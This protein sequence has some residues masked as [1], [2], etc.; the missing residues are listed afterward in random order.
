MEY[1][2]IT[3]LITLLILL[4]FMNDNNTIK[5]LSF[6]VICLILIWFSGFKRNVGN[7][8]IWYEKFFKETESI[9]KIIKGFKV[10]FSESDF[11]IGYKVLNAIVK[12]FTLEP[13]FIFVTIAFV[14]VTIYF[15]SVRR[16]T[17]HYLIA[18]LLLFNILF[19]NLFME[20]IRQGIA[21]IIF[22]YSIKFIL[23]KKLILFTLC[24][25][26]AMTFHFSAILL[27]PFYFIL[28]K[29]IPKVA[30]SIVLILGFIFMLTGKG[31]GILGLGL[32]DNTFE[33]IDTQAKVYLASQN[34][35]YGLGLGYFERVLFIVLALFFYK[36]ITDDPYFRIFFNLYFFG[37]IIYSFFTDFQMIPLRIGLYFKI[38]TIICYAK[39][40]DLTQSSR[41]KLLIVFGIIAF[42]FFNLYVFIQNS[43]GTWIPYDNYFY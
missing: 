13:Q 23:D 41:I 21:V 25:S 17:E 11:E 10:K 36:E 27:F 5:L 39:A 1:L 18:T 3:L 9:L 32:L 14:M 43:K 20:G 16:Y 24:I 42:A 40:I 4:N 26:V 33:Y 15:I 2:L 6:S 38:S 31:F 12:E 37:Y 35:G 29:K 7:D 22:F 28:N 19:V 30:I 34:S 8:S